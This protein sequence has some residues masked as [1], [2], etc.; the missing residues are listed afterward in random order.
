MRQ[1]MISVSNM[2]P[3]TVPHVLSVKALSQFG[4]SGASCTLIFF[5]YPAVDGGELF[6][7]L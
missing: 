6:R 2:M 5:R 1:L 7:R 3:S 4:Q